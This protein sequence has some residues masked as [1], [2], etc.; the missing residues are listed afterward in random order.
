MTEHRS[1]GLFIHM[2]CTVDNGHI[3]IYMRNLCIHCEVIG[4]AYLIRR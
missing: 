1:I 3:Q 4:L 2:I